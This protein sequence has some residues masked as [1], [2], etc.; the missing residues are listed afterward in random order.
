MA[1]LSKGQVLSYLSKLS[2]TQKHI[3]STNCQCARAHSSSI[4]AVQSSSF[5]PLCRQI[6]DCWAPICCINEITSEQS[7]KSLPD[8]FISVIDLMEHLTSRFSLQRFWFQSFKEN[9]CLE[10]W[11]FCSDDYKQIDSIWAFNTG[12]LVQK[13][14][15]EIWE[16]YVKF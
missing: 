3:S 14:K 7:H 9:F 15:K 16:I 4:S 6:C 10:R 12:S 5:L 8:I 1:E 2:P 11:N 13:K